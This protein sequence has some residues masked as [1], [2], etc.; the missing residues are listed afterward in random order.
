MVQRHGLEGMHRRGLSAA[1][2]EQEVEHSPTVGRRRRR[3]QMRVED[4]LLDTGSQAALPRGVRCDPIHHLRAPEAQIDCPLM[5]LRRSRRPL[6]GTILTSLSMSPAW[7]R[8]LPNMLRRSALLGHRL[9]APTRCLGRVT[10]LRHSTCGVVGDELD[11]SSTF[12]AWSSNWPS[13]S[14]GW[15][16]RERNPTCI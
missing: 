9:A 2:G 14:T 16:L 13:A 6:T 7:Q 12:V 3:L 4:I 5:I 15:P 1:Y 8:R 11:V 10:T